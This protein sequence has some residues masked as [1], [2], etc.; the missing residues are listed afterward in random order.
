MAGAP[1]VP[2]APLLELVIAVLDDVPDAA[3]PAPLA[4]NPRSSERA[5]PRDGVVHAAE[6]LVPPRCVARVGE[7][8][9][10]LQLEGTELDVFVDVVRHRGASS[11]R[12]CSA[13]SALRP[14]ESSTRKVV[15][16]RRYVT[17]GFSARRAVMARSR[18]VTAGSGASSVR[19]PRSAGRMRGARV[20]APTVFGGCM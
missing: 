16:L 7:L 4:P 3:P 12:R 1:P 19:P 9:R 17:P 13:A 18:A 14:S 5:P 8:A 2:P 10:V 20:T 15:G 11:Q 6:R